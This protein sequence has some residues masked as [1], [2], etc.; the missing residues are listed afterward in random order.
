M[1]FDQKWLN[2]KNRDFRDFRWKNIQKIVFFAQK[3]HE[4]SKMTFF[5]DWFLVEFCKIVIFDE[6]IVFRFSEETRFYGRIQKLYFFAQKWVISK[7]SISECPLEN[8]KIFSNRWCGA[9]HLVWITMHRAVTAV[10]VIYP[11]EFTTFRQRLIKTDRDW[12]RLIE[13]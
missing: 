6:K 2:L 1:E 13:F 12:S 3:W 5:S 9:I 7:I 10:C 4:R 11:I 8:F